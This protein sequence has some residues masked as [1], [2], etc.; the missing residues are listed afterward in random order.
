M[1]VWNRIKCVKINME[2]FFF[3]HPGEVHYIKAIVVIYSSEVHTILQKLIAHLQ[4]KFK[5]IYTTFN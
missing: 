2:G 3:L 5:Y 1:E 4:G